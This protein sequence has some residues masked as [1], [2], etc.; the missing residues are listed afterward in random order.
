MIKWLGQFYYLW[1]SLMKSQ[2]IPST[3]TALLGRFPFVRTGRPD[4]SRTSQIENEIGFFEEFLLKMF[5]FLNI[6]YD[7]TDLAREF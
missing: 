4:H 2:P 6:I 3:S 1:L 7:L 5:S